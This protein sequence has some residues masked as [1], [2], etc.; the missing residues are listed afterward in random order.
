MHGATPTLLGA[1][2]AVL[3]LASPPAPKASDPEAE[4]RACQEGCKDQGLDETDIVT[5]RLNC[6]QSVEGKRDA[7]VIRWTTEKPVGGT[8]PGQEVAPTVTTVTK[9]APDGSTTQSTTTATPTVATKPT[10]RP[11]VVA[12]SPRRRYYFGLVD[13]QDRCNA[14]RDDMPRARCKLRCLKLQPGPP[15]PRTPAAPE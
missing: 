7:D 15:P 12:D 1:A 14:T 8:V 3:G 13:C 4:I 5:C 11:K 9:I 2:L 10:P 6:R